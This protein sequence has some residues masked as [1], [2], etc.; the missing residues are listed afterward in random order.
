MADRDGPG[1]RV[2]AGTAAQPVP[3]RP[4]ARGVRPA[5]CFNRN[6]RRHLSSVTWIGHFMPTHIGGPEPQFIILKNTLNINRI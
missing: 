5:P 6:C 1:R 4:H 2:D 3:P